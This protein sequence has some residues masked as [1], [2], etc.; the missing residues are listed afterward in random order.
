MSGQRG[1]SRRGGLTIATLGVAIV[2]FLSL[3]AEVVRGEGWDAR[4][5][6][7]PETRRAD[8]QPVLDLTDYDRL[9][10]TYL[11]DDGWVGYAGNGCR[12]PVVHEERLMS[13]AV[14]KIV[15]CVSWGHSGVSEE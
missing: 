3:R 2:L 13:G 6:A 8:A 5:T 14:R 7:T 15:G 9:L 11:T 1:W 4:Q 10:Q 12:R